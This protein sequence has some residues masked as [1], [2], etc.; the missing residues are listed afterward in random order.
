MHDQSNDRKGGEELRGIF[1]TH[2]RAE[3]SYDFEEEDGV[4]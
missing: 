2:R 4:G 1:G 3:C